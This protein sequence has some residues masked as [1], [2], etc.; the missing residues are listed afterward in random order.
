MMT[1]RVSRPSFR[2]LRA[3]PTCCHLGCNTA[4]APWE[5]TYPA[6]SG[7]YLSSILIIAEQGIHHHRQP[8]YRHRPV[9]RL[10]RDTSAKQCPLQSKVTDPPA[11]KIADPYDRSLP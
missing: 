10:R 6:W 1:R 4:T 9:E 3:K 11:P 8:A 2:A 7:L 5:G